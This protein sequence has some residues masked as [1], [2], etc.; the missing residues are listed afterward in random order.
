MLAALAP[1][2]HRA[3]GEG[4]EVDDKSPSMGA[5]SLC[6]PFTQPADGVVP[7]MTKCFACAAYAKSYTVF[8][9]SY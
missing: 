9:R 8:G 2:S 3:P 7:G 6:I 5:K 4:G 1:H